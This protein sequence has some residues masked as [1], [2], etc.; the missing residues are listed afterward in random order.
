MKNPTEELTAHILF[1]WDISLTLN[2]TDFFFYVILNA[3][4]NPTEELTGIYLSLRSWDI[5]L[6]LN[7]TKKKECHCEPQ[8]WQTPRKSA[9]HILY[10]FG[11]GI[12]R[13]RSIWRTW[14]GGLSRSLCSLAMT[15]GKW[16]VGYFAYAQY[17]VLF[18]YVILSMS[19]R[20]ICSQTL[21]KL[22]RAPK[23]KRFRGAAF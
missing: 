4:K 6:T 5:S 18:L 8:A 21:A 11:R 7:M 10:H 1:R 2:M 14:F 17:D 3:V 23:P 16:V 19:S 13:L 22:K 12:F 15:A 9:E 20:Q